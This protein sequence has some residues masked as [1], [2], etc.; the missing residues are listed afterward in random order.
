MTVVTIYYDIQL[1]SYLNIIRSIF[2]HG[3]DRGGGG[4]NFRLVRFFLKKINFEI[5]F[6]LKSIPFSPVVLCL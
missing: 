3:G 5:F 4:G 1:F 6:Q 2:L